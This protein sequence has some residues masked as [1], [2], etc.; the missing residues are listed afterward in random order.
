LQ[1]EVAG[2]KPG[3]VPEPSKPA[4]ER[5]IAPATKPGQP[6]VTPKDPVGAA[7]IVQV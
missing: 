4:A 3:K 6:G 7:G 1:K 2:H 5:P